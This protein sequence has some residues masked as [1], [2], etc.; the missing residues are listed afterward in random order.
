MATQATPIESSIIL[1]RLSVASPRPPA[2][3]QLRCGGQLGPVSQRRTD[4]LAHS[5][6]VGLHAE[7]LENTLGDVAHVHM[8]HRIMLAVPIAICKRCV[9]QN[10]CQPKGNL[11]VKG[12]QRLLP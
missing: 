4:P 8:G 1:G 11:A 9:R 10:R 7:P 6:G 12:L 2:S 3:L 5:L